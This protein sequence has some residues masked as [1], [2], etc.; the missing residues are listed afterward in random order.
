MIRILLVVLGCLSVGLGALGTFTPGLPT[1]PFI[2]LASWA[3]YRSSPQTSTVAVKLPIGKIHQRIPEAKGA[4][5]QKEALCHRHDGADV[6][7]VNPV[8]HSDSDSQNHSGMC[9]ADW[10]HCSRFFCTYG[11]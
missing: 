9:R 10:K 6:Y 1:T 4:H 5:R 8:L 3:F 7:A 11:K 2:L